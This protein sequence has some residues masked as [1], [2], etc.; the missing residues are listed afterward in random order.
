MEN[1]IFLAEVRTTREDCSRP[2]LFP[3]SGAETAL[4]LGLYKAVKLVG[5][6][7]GLREGYIRSVEELPGRWFELDPQPIQSFLAW[8]SD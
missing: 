2:F 7:S 6:P 5:V 8:L 1:I 3:E 4:G